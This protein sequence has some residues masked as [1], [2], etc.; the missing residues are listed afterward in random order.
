M[1]DPSLISEDGTASE[2]YFA[3]PGLAAIGTL[4]LAPISGPWYFSTDMSVSKRFNL[5]LREGSELEITAYFSNIFNR[6]NFDIDSTPD[7]LDSVISVYNAQD[8]NSTSFGL[9]QNAFSA[10]EAQLGIKVIF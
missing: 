5:G 10:R 9:I 7:A 4:G 2:T 8:I 1:F 6:A 3:N